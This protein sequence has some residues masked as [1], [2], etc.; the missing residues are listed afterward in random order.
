MCSGIEELEESNW[1][2]KSRNHRIETLRENNVQRTYEN[3][4]VTL[5]AL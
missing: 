4:H 3:G 1:W 5:W 2:K